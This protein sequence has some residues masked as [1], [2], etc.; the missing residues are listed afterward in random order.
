MWWKEAPLTCVQLALLSEAMI[1]LRGPRS[2]DESGGGRV[3]AITRCS[4]E[5]AVTTPP[6]LWSITIGLPPEMLTRSRWKVRV[7][8]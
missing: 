7:S 5:N 4:H 8:P 1:N 3:K 2:L 6:E